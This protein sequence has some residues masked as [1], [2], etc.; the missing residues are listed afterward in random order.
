MEWRQQSAVSC[1][2]A[3]LEAQRWLEEVTKKHFGSKSFRVALEDGVLL[4]DLINTLKP[5]I[6][7]RVNRLSTPIAGLDNV[8]VFLKACEK[9]GLNEAQLFHPGD[10]QDV[11]T[12]VTVR[13]E[14][15]SRRLKNV[16]ITIYWL[17]RKAQSD[18]FYT[19]PQLN[20]KAFEGLLGTALSKALEETV[21]S[22][23]SVRDSGYAEGW[24]SDREDLFS[25]KQPGYRR[26]DSVESLD[27][28][29][30][31]TLSAAS[32]C[33]LRAGSEGCCSDAEA[34]HCF[35][36]AEDHKSDAPIRERVHV[37]SALR[38]KR[39]EYQQGDRS[40]AGNLT[41][42]SG[43][44]LCHDLPPASAFLQWASSY[45]SDSDSDAERPEPD[46][47]Q[48]DLAG[49]RF[50]SLT[51]VAPVNFA[52]PSKP[53]G[54]RVAPVVTPSA[55]KSWLTLSDASRLAAVPPQR[56][57]QSV[58]SVPSVNGRAGFE[59]A[60]LEEEFLQQ[61]LNNGMSDSDEDR[62]YADPV[63]D[64][65]YTRRVLVS[66]HQTSVKADSDKFLPKYWTPEE[67]LHVKK[68]RLGSQRRPW[69]KKMQGLRS[70]S[71]G[72]ITLEPI[73]QESDTCSS[74]DMLGSRHVHQRSVGEVT[75]DPSAIQRVQQEQ[76]Q[77][78]RDRIKESEAR[79][80]EDLSRWK[81]RRRS[82]NS[83]LHRKRE[84][85]EQ[86]EIITSGGGTSAI[87]TAPLTGVPEES[88]NMPGP[89]SDAGS[90]VS[91]TGWSTTSP[92][93]N[94]TSSALTRGTDTET[95]DSAG[96]FFTPPSAVVPEQSSLT[97]DPE[98]YEQQGPDFSRRASLLESFYA[99]GARV[100][101]TLPRGYRRSEGSSRLS[102]GVTPRPFGAKPSKVSPLPRVYSMDDSHKSLISGNREHSIIPSFLSSQGKVTASA[103][104]GHFRSSTH[105]IKKEEERR[106]GRLSAPPIN[107]FATK[108]SVAASSVQ[109][110]PVASE[111][112]DIK[113]GQSE[114]RVCLNQKPNSGRDF[115][116]KAHWDSTGACVKSV[117]AGSPA[118]LCGLLMGDEIVAL[119]GCR[120]AEMNYE[121]FKGSMDTAQ[122]KGTLLMDIRRHGQNDW[123]SDQ[124]SLP[125][126][127][128]KTINLTSANSTLI[129]RPEQYV[130]ISA[131]S[132]VET[133]V[134]TQFN[135][136][137]ANG[138][139]SKMV[140]GRIQDSPASLRSKGGSESAIS[141]LQVPSISTTSSRW[142]WDHEEE[143]RRQEKW[144]MEQERLLQEK[145][146]RDQEK[147]EQE[148]RRAQ[149]EVYGEEHSGTEELKCADVL[150]NGNTT[151]IPSPFFNQSVGTASVASNQNTEKVEAI[152]NR[153]TAVQTA[154][155]QQPL[156]EEEEC[157][158]T[159]KSQCSEE[160]YGF[161]KLTVSDRTKSKST[162]ALQGL[163]KQDAKAGSGK[164][165]GQ[166]SKAEKERLQI[167]EEM[168]KKTPL[169]TDNSWIR[170][171]NA[172]INKEPITVGTS[173]R[174]YESLDNLHST[175]SS[176]SRQ[177]YT[178][179]IANR[180]H[181]ALGNT[182][183]YRSGRSS[184]GPDSAIFSTGLKQSS[185]FASNSPAPPFTAMP[186]PSG[187][188]SRPN[189]QQSGRL[190]SGRRMCSRCEQPLGK[191]AAMVIDSLELCF[192]IGC[193]KCVSCR[194]DLGRGTESGAQVRVR[195]R[196]LFCNTCYSRIR[197][198][199]SV[200]K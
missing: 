27:S 195:H 180:P 37:P 142:S 156:K 132:P 172:S 147:L 68:I 48:D 107:S 168:R 187:P 54:P 173:I 61:T 72:D 146:Q 77:S 106:D 196:Q 153:Q 165:K 133:M 96:E 22:K 95:T 57:N 64:D 122:Q 84:E 11:S 115:G 1:E 85:R 94:G 80:H 144:Q 191:G 40:Y 127:S 131:T 47:V 18:P 136:Q 51:S 182:G 14:E 50:R 28:V 186:E 184:L 32:D 62:G 71:T 58:S 87:R 36:M 109:K 158:S 12:R 120:V 16:L 139:L 124:P 128:H 143:R 111:I 102:T 138:V 100:S 78:I 70:K 5:G 13:R 166:L 154:A 46:L 56:S 163:H 148:W 81:S 49:R 39:Q 112:R 97:M 134:K 9:L 66:E 43:R 113:V 117:Q 185:S 151:Y 169:L 74:F 198:C 69:Y 59:T 199:S 79:W 125:Y 45:Q 192:H 35:R 53:L 161:A 135:G 52:I 150:S 31:R 38:K 181:S 101:A 145:Y 110:S 176:W 129:G 92:L 34:E 140:N 149:Q 25:L 15:T 130:S 83:D 155:A 157:D 4:C 197:V 116:F 103:D 118:E 171:R 91:S 7:K 6:I 93:T 63:L 20:L 121:Q 67:D 167:L 19:G 60:T 42:E 44:G 159:T 65:L 152:Q 75:L 160:S 137:A 2:L 119:G 108:V 104:T 193:F 8:N 90:S 10:L 21:Q 88:S 175:N 126:K 190:V 89:M 170:Q 76:L 86:I 178:S 17:G 194:T 105:P 162:P 26:E 174:R 23:S 73:A 183:T 98:A 33:T 24:F 41:S 3:F 177:S 123:G 55:R 141:D 188:K 189:S 30:S 164:K 179:S 29:E 114:M 99:G 200:S 82:T